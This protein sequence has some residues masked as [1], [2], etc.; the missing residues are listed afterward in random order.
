MIDNEEMIQSPE[1]I[2]L[3]RFI[4]DL[5]ADKKAEDIVLL[6][7]REQSIIADYFV[8][9]CG[10][11]ERQI[12]AIISDIPQEVKNSYQ[13]LARAIE[14][15]PETGWVLIDFYDVIVHVFNQ[16]TREYY[17]LE[18]FWSEATTLLRMQ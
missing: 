12:K 16:Q 4:V 2:E 9:C 17:D 10:T 18:A 14:G 1:P 15:K 6:D 7:I 13:L 5:A 8:I 3:A 11:S